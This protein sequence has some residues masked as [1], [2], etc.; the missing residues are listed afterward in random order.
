MEKL[1]KEEKIELCVKINKD[2]TKLKNASYIKPINL[3]CLMDYTDLISTLQDRD[4]VQLA[5]K[6]TMLQSELTEKISE[7]ITKTNELQDMIDYLS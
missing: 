1:S 3:N 6:I 4:Y 2:L 5:D 7:I